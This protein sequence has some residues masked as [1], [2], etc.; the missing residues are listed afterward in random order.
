MHSILLYCYA[1]RLNDGCNS[2]L[3]LPQLG[4]IFQFLEVIS[5]E[6]DDESIT[7]NCIGLVGDLAVSFAHHA[8]EVGTRC[9]YS[10]NLI[11][12]K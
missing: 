5:Q 6:N 11:H 7:K 2:G 8:G 9:I 10:N 12:K 4:N 1:H 3:I